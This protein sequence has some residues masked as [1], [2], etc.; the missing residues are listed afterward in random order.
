MRGV[1]LFIAGLGVGLAVESGLAQ[2]ENRGIVG[3]NHVALSVPNLDEA[4][5]YYTKTMGFPEAF[6]SKDDKGQV[7]LVYVQIS[8]DTFVELQPAN[9]QR[10]AGI[11][12]FGLVVQDMKAATNMFKQR[13]ANV[14]DI[15]VSPTKAILSNMTDPYG[16][17]IELAEL[18]PESAHRQAMERW[19]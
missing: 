10:P 15:R 13:G 4:L 6:R 1:F 16:V 18:P 9:P 14:S 2:T 7:T 3:L 12:H 5:T 8:R 17:R 11:N 19:K